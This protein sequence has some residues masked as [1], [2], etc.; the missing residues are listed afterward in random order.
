MR[1]NDELLHTISRYDIE[2]VYLFRAG[3]IINKKILD[4]GIDIL[5]T[6]CARIPDYGGLGA[7]ARALKDS[8]FDQVATLHRVTETIDDG[9]IV[10][11]EPYK[12]NAALSYRKNEDI[13][14]EAGMRLLLKRFMQ[15]FNPVH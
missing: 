14:Y 12:L 11:T 3:L 13:A 8:S 5:N 15:E 7:I 4:S 10:A 2:Q 1:N 6:H 9:E